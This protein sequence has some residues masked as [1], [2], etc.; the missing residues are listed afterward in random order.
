MTGA[1]PI[2]VLVH[3]FLGT[4]Q[5]WDPVR[6]SLAARGF[7][8]AF[9]VDLLEC[10]QDPACASAL[11][12]A[13]LADPASPA[14]TDGLDTLAAAVRRR[15]AAHADGSASGRRALALCGYSL[16]GRVC[17]ALAGIDPSV[18]SCIVVGADPGIED[19]RERPLRAGRDHAHATHLRQDP[20]GFLSAWYAQ[21]LFA[22]LRASPAFA[23]VVARRRACLSEP[24]TRECWATI[25][26]ACSPGR[27]APRWGAAAR[28]GSRLAAV[29]GALDDKFAGI[30]R[31]LHGL[32]PQTPT[33]A[34]P[35]AGHAA[36][37]EQPEACA[38]AIASI[39]AAPHPSTP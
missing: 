32:S 8:D 17:L 34:V 35:G 31:R 1:A 21:P 6:R 20:D 28:L 29:Y 24:R 36:H 25:L 19:P 23:P 3:G 30:A 10:A 16:G 22:S 39:I 12:R 15:I 9:T 37:V 27:C 33:I 7:P 5:D 26:E 2:V 13:A 4:P 38:D 11:E 14:V 18:S